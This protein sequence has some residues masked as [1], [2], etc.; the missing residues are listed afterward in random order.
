MSTINDADFAP[1]KPTFKDVVYMSIRNLTNFPYI[2]KDFDAITDYELLCKV[3]E[4]L[5]NLISNNNTQ[6]STITGLYNAYVELQ[7]YVNNYFDDLDVQDEI[8]NKLES[9]AADGS[10]TAL[11]K[12]YVDPIYEA[13]EEEINSDINTQN[14]KITQIENLV[15]SLAS[16]SPKGVYATTSALIS[17]NPDTGVYIVTADGHIYS[18]SKDG[19]SPID[20]GVYQ[21]TGIDDNSI[22]ISMLNSTINGN[23]YH[24]D[25]TG[26]YPALY[27]KFPNVETLTKIVFK[28]KIKLLDYFNSPTTAFRN[29]LYSGLNVISGS[30][31]GQNSSGNPTES[32]NEIGDLVSSGREWVDFTF[33]YSSP[34]L[35]SN[36]NGFSFGLNTNKNDFTF[37]YLFKDIEIYV[38]NEKTNYEMIIGSNYN[39]QVTIETEDI[40][41]LQTH[42]Q[43]NSTINNLLE[44]YNGATKSN[45]RKI[46]CWGDS[47]TEGTMPSGTPYPSI[48]QS[49]LGSDYTV[50]NLGVNGNASGA[51]AFREGGIPLQVASNF[52]IPASG[53]VEVSLKSTTDFKSFIN[54]HTFNVTIEG[55]A[56]TLEITDTDSG[57]TGTG[58][59]TRT[60][61]GDAT[62]VLANT[63]FI[64]SQAT[65]DDNTSIIWVGANDN[66]NYQYYTL[67]NIDSMI[68]ILETSQDYPS[69]IVCS[70]CMP[71]TYDNA[72]SGSGA[73]ITRINKQ[74]K[75]SYR[76][77]YVDLNNYLVNQ[78]IYDL[79]LTPSAGDLTRMSNGAIPEV[80]FSDNIHFTDAC[81]Q[82]IGRFLFDELA[83]RHYI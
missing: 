52:T 21:S 22:I 76:S 63:Y 18:W 33:T 6:N 37:E 78:C 31:T 12:G 24:Y 53:S 59:F 72:S 75:R 46:A 26:S 81:R 74:L 29:R 19:D 51:V 32:I 56:G 43:N 3:V 8:N 82:Q 80:L 64:S 25:G 14:G 77:H 71:K 73:W 5:N 36:V 30:A 9:M 41:F 35:T 79:G 7:D 42:S 38:N 83:K 50:Y 65:H 54:T 27:F 23:I 39:S 44:Y 48:I 16:G 57:L 61:A 55:I 2:E 4:H 69:Y 15:N 47:L 1:T 66:L 10:L 62:S 68:K 45:N 17:A 60:S 70:V 58:S 40:D 34:Q 11:I 28:G 20:L 13:F 49:L 67:F